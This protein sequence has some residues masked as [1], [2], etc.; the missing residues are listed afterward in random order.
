M[1]AQISLGYAYADG[2]GVPKDRA[3]AVRWWRKAADQGNAEAQNSL[4]VAYASGEG[5]P[6]DFSEAVLWYRRAADQGDPAAQ[7]NL[8]VSYGNGTGV[9]QDFAEA[10]F[11]ENLAAALKK[12]DRA[13]IY[14][15]LRD[16][17]AARLSPAEL[18]ATQSRCRQW[19]DAFEKRKVQK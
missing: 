3:E 6:Q 4:G 19:T 18:S 15:G 10:Y 14:A 7:L 9:P 12:G 13:K 5:V 11:W 17:T 1:Y 16:K 8:G 2:I